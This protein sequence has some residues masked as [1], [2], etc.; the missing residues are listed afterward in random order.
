[1]KYQLPNFFITNTWNKSGYRGICIIDQE[2]SFIC[3]Y[4]ELGVYSHC[5]ARM[6]SE[7]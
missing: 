6:P 4:L 3:R 2:L 5:V 7:F 1:M